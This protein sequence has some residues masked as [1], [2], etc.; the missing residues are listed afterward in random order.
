MENARR[1]F[2]RTIFGVAALPAIGSVLSLIRLRD[3]RARS[4]NVSLNALSWRPKC[5]Y[6]PAREIHQIGRV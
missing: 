3:P 6:R 4:V 5:M 2:L 1:H